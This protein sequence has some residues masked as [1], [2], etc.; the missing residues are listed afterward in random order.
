M[1]KLTLYF[2]PGACSLVPHITLE[3]A[4]ATFEAKPIAL[5]KGDQRT[6]EYLALNPKGKVPVLLIDGRPLTE[7]VAIASYLAKTFPNAK[8]LPSGDPEAEAQALSLLAWCSS[9]VHP[10]IGAFFGP[11]RLCDLPDSAASVTRL[12]GEDTAKNFAMVDKL[13]AGKGWALGQW[14]IVDAYL[15]VFWRW[16][17]FLKIDVGGYPNYAKHAARMAERPSVK[18]ALAREADAQASLDK[19]A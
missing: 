9:G 5:K 19:A 13:L 4:G 17:G 8:L 6:P 18:R 1:P 3:E 15:Y 14:S 7:N 12:A 10:R 2:S 11:Q 16:A